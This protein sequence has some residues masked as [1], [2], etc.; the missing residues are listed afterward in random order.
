M[1]T[2][3]ACIAILLFVTC[4]SVRAQTPA[5]KRVPCDSQSPA[6]AWRTYVD[7]IHGF[8]FRYPSR[9]KRLPSDKNQPI[10][11]QSSHSDAYIFVQFENKPFNLQRF[12]ET[13]PTGVE[14]PPSPV[15]VGEYTFYYYGPGGG[16]VSYPDTYF[17]NLGGK[18]LYITFDGPYINDKT[19]SAETKKLERELLATF[20]LF[21]D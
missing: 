10:K 1:K 9:Y 7:R 2:N 20:R 6:D 17:F 4:Y 3:P 16:G 18:T 11:F 19:P 8:C 15:H 12:A 13:A 5:G 21:G 14:S